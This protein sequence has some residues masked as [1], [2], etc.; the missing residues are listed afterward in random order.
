ME[1]K[2]LKNYKQYINKH[3][4][5]VEKGFSILKPFLKDFLSQEE[6]SALSKNIKAH[7]NSKFQDD[8]FFAYAEHFYGNKSGSNFEQAKRL[9][10]ARNPHHPEYW[11][12]K[13]EEMPKIYVVEMVL[14]WWSFGIMQNNPSEIFSFYHSH[15]EG[16]NLTK[17]ETKTVEQILSAIKQVQGDFQNAFQ[18]K[19]HIK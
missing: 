6:F 2:I 17:S 19:I 5:C 3:K 15:Q 9:H 11:K 18:S 8:E 14:D 12:T 4:K 10:K 16:L 1:E 7:D 13:N